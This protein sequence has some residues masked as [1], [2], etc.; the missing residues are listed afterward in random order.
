MAPTLRLWFRWELERAE[1]ETGTRATARL[2]LALERFDEM[3]ALRVDR[4]GGCCGQRGTGPGP[5]P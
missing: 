4:K 3:P 1:T 5:E 2:R